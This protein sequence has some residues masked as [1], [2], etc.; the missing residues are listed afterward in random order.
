LKKFE[1]KKR[2]TNDVRRRGKGGRSNAK[3]V[4]N[5]SREFFNGA[6][7]FPGVYK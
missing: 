4:F 6:L 5:K 1:E 2:K 3:D 7:D